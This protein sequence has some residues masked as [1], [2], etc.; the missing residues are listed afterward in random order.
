M[1]CI[2]SG[3]ITLSLSEFDSCDKTSSDETT[4]SKRCCNFNDITFNFDYDTNVNLKTF[5]ST[6]PT[7]L[8]SQQILA[9]KPSVPLTDNFNNYTSLPPPGGMEFL[10]RVQVFR[11]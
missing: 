2:M 7:L 8:L 4:I 6:I 10:K 3:N 11:L 1:E 9:I 5:K